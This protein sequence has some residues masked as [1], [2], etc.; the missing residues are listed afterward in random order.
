MGSNEWQDD[1]LCR[2]IG[3][4]PFFDDSGAAESKPSVSTRIR[5]WRGKQ[6]CAACP[7]ADACLAYAQASDTKYGV[8]G[9]LDQ[10]ERALLR[11]DVPPA[12]Q[13]ADVARRLLFD[14]ISFPRV[15]RRLGVSI[16]ELR[17]W[18]VTY[19][20]TATSRQ[21][22]TEYTAWHDVEDGW[23]PDYVSRTHQIPPF[24]AEEMCRA[25]DRDAD[26]GGPKGKNRY[27]MGAA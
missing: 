24:L 6:L 1:A 14:G 25:M 9:G 19:P 20:G 21:L 16:E 8:F 23:P 18:L 11:R 12:K 10:R 17:L 2:S 7:V 15:A 27:S 4:G 22:L 5:R 26:Y 3:C 13:L